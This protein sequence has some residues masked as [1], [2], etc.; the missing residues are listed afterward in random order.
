MTC[1]LGGQGSCRTQ[2]RL[3]WDIV[4]PDRD[5]DM[6]EIDSGL[7]SKRGDQFSVTVPQPGGEGGRRSDQ[8][9]DSGIAGRDI[10]VARYHRPDHGLKVQQGLDAGVQGVES[11]LVRAKDL[12]GPAEGIW[13]ARHWPGEVELNCTHYNRVPG[14][15]R[16]LLA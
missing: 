16:S 2:A 9:Y 3:R 12:G 4:R 6:L 13:N 7:V 8:M 5:L 15:L 11:A 10:D 1:V 14:E